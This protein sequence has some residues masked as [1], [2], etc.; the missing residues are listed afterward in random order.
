MFQKKGNV[1]Q[2]YFN[3]DGGHSISYRI[4]SIKRPGHLLNFWTLRVGAYSRWALIRGWALIKFY[5]FCI[6]MFDQT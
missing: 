5:I 3:F 4:Y 2:L 6:N 1:K